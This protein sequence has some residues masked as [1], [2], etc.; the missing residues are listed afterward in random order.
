MPLTCLLV[1]SGSCS[2]SSPGSSWPKGELFDSGRRSVAGWLTEAWHH[3]CSRAGARVVLAA[4]IC[5]QDES[6]MQNRRLLVAYQDPVPS[7]S[8]GFIISCNIFAVRFY[9][10][11]T[12][13]PCR[14]GQPLPPLSSLAVL[15]L[16]PLTTQ[17]QAPPPPPQNGATGG[18]SRGWR[19]CPAVPISSSHRG[20]EDAQ[21][22]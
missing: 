4:K 13:W 17:P 6:L 3:T 14:G 15:P 18:V 19:R 2:W 9:N 12:L 22:L 10:H 20:E 21:H 11:R 7:R 8:P 1:L 16:A 5:R